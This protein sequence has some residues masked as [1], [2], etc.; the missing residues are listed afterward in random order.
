MAIRREGKV[1]VPHKSN[2]FI[3]LTRTDGM[4]VKAQLSSIDAWVEHFH[5]HRGID[6]I[7]YFTNLSLV[8]VRES[9]DWID[10]EINGKAVPS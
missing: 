2:A 9:F 6:V 3:T 8:G 7:V 4:P 10:A 1:K 5:Q